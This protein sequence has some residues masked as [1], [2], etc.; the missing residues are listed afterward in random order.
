[1]VTR[2]RT[3]RRRG[4]VA[5]SRKRVWARQNAVIVSDITQAAPQ[6]VS[7]TAQFQA[8]YGADP[9][10][11]TI[12]RTYVQFRATQTAGATMLATAGGLMV[13]LIE[14]D[15]GDSGEFDVSMLAA[16]TRHMDW[17]LQKVFHPEPPLGDGYIRGEIDIKAM[18]KMEE[19]GEAYFVVFQAT[20]PAQTFQVE[21]SAATLLLLP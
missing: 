15:I 11:S 4:P 2:V 20:A 13:G 5:P 9:V 14:T 17:S 6:G 10:G 21:F 18:R 12:V 16:G 8:D 3:A 19:M 1:M 7:L